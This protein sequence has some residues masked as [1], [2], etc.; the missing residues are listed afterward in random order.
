MLRKRILR[1]LLS[2]HIITTVLHASE[3]SAL[4]THV[5]RIAETFGRDVGAVEEVA[6]VQAVVGG[7]G[8][9]SAED[10]VVDVD[11]VVFLRFGAADE[12]GVGVVAHFEE[13]AYLWMRSAKESE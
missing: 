10:Y 6:V 11:A 9:V 7:E 3:T 5:L 4:R 2:V 8:A 12:N 13:W 1:V